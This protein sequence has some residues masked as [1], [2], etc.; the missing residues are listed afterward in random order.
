[1]KGIVLAGVCGTLMRTV[2]ELRLRLRGFKRLA[3]PASV[4]GLSLESKG[5][6]D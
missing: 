2:A 1:M 6:G 5:V 3:Q 4:S